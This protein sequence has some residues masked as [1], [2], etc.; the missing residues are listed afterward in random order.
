MS[1]NR[2]TDLEINLTFLDETVDQL[3]RVIIEQNKRIDA[4]QNLVAGLK[5]DIDESKTG[6]PTNQPPPHY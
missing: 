6:A 4:L 1:E 2:L 5:N 3:N